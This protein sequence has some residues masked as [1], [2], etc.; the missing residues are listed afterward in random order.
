MTWRALSISMMK[1]SPRHKR[2]LH[3]R[4]LSYME[5]YD[6]ASTVH[7]SL[8]TGYDFKEVSSSSYK[9][10]SLSVA[11]K[12]HPVAV[13]ATGVYLCVQAYGDH[14]TTFTLQA[15]PLPHSL[16]LRLLTF[17]TPSGFHLVNDNKLSL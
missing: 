3:P 2:I 7:Q 5:S 11:R 12:D 13:D 17:L 14:N 4:C 8:T 9:T 10:V 6:V 1:S 15:G 16:P